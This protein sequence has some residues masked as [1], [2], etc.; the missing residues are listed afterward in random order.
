M[1]TLDQFVTEDR[2]VLFAAQL[3]I[4][5]TPSTLYFSFPGY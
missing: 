2:Q 3:E 1:A 4:G 5:G